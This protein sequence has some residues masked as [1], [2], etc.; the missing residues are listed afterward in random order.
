M[1]WRAESSGMTLLWSMIDLRYPSEKSSGWSE[2][3]N[4]T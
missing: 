3:R 1:I 2:S 4:S